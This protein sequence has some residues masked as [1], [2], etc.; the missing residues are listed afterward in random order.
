MI[1]P[2]RKRNRPV[3]RLAEEAQ[4]PVPTRIIEIQEMAPRLHK[5]FVIDSIKNSWDSPPSHYHSTTLITTST[6]ATTRAQN[7]GRRNSG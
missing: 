1:W 2:N 6:T 3:G 7:T 5:L 4:L